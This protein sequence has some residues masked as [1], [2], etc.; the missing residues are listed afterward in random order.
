[1]PLTSRALCS[2]ELQLRNSDLKYK[3]RGKDPSQET[4][5]DR[6]GSQ[7]NIKSP[8]FCGNSARKMGQ[9]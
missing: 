5:I 2:G 8:R 4:E 6:L 9:E 3:K 1:M 7:S